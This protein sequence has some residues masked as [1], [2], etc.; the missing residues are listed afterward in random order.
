MRIEAVV[1]CHNYS[2]FL[3]HTLPENVELLDR[4]VVVTHPDDKDT[5]KLCTKYG[6]DCI[7]TRLMHEDNDKFNKGR[8]INLGLSHLR[9]EDWLLHMDADVLLPH[10]FRK[11]LD[12][13][14]LKSENIYGADRLNCL[15]FDNWERHKHKI[16]PQH[17]WRFMVTPVSEFPLGSRL[18]HQEYGYCPI[19]YFQ[20]WHSS[21]RKTYPIVTG[22]AEHSDVMFAV[23]W[24]R[25]NRIL[26]PELFVFHLESD[27]DLPMGINWNGRKSKR[28]GHHHGHEPGKCY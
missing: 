11:M 24:A 2:D 21:Q 16:H 19:G 4:L 25:E 18:I 10:K 26:L 9:H 17:Q 15:S 3:E 22:S 8:C 12:Y 14:K 28:F 27:G 1:V 6:V 23:Q 13:A 7:P 20:L 5:Q